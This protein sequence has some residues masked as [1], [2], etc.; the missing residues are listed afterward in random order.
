MPFHFLNKKLTLQFRAFCLTSGLVMSS[1]LV[2][3]YF[4]INNMEAKMYEEYKAR[5][6]IIVKYFAQNSNESILI[7]DIDS[8][9]QTIQRLF[10][11]GEVVYAAI[12]DNENELLADQS[13][14]VIDK[15]LM[16]PT[17]PVGVEIKDV[18]TG[19]DDL[20]VLIF[21]TPVV[22]EENRECVGFVR[23]GL[24]LVKVQ[25]DVET[26]IFE[27][28]I[29]LISFMLISALI[30]YL[31]SRSLSNPIIKVVKGLSKVAEYVNIKSAQTAS[32]SQSLSERTSEQAAA[33]QEIFSSI[34]MMLFMTK[35]NADNAFQANKLMTE[36]KL[37]VE[38]A[39]RTMYDLTD[40]IKEIN[41]SGEETFKIIKTIDEIAFQTNLLAL[42]A[43]VESARAGEA[44]SGFA[45][46]A[47]EV[48][49]LAVRAADAAKNTSSLIENT[50][51]QITDVSESMLKTNVQFSEISD[52][53]L[54]IGDLVG[55]ITTTS[56]QQVQ[57]I[58]Q[59]TQGI[60]E[61]DKAT[62]CN[63]SYSEESASES[64]ELNA[65]AMQMKTFVSELIVLI[66][67]IGKRKTEFS[68]K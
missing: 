19:N 36:S 29:I 55:T 15:K 28:S 62:Q 3:S 63:A 39:K 25:N 57:G 64:E 40:L 24:S 56:E 27:S 1:I 54:K 6:K 50:V 45:V 12:F 26:M 60:M 61:M 43:A 4:F 35:Q 10:E 31:F 44:G 16:M 48:R 13:S 47:D 67:N 2:I 17:K 11:I 5:G 9:K 8:L 32:A 20:P 41:E 59:A 21:S 23:I 22:I 46:V 66:G 68:Q 52:I 51:K 37:L 49:N 14:I 65:Q 53:S 42:N 58:E 7:E 30:S 18:L 33:S 38:N 34:E